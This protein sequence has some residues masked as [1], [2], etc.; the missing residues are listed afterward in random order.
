[1]T[2]IKRS[3]YQ[4]VVEENK[5]LMKDLEILVISE[6]ADQFDKVFMKWYKH[7][8]NEETFKNLLKNAIIHFAEDHPN[9]ELSNSIAKH[10]KNQS[11]IKNQTSALDESNT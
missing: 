1:M 3:T 4:K 2:D 5:R 7:F 10:F 9:I 6:N 11:P 8:M